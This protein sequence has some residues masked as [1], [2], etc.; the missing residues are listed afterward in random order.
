MLTE[1]AQGLKL[2]ETLYKDNYRKLYLYSRAVLRN[3]ELGEEAVQDTFCIACDKIDQVINSG[4]P[5]GWLMNTLKN[6]IRNMEH[7]RSSIYSYLRQTL[8]YKDE[9]LGAASDEINVDLQYEGLISDA[10]FE[11]LKM[12][13]LDKLT[14]LEASNHYG[15]TLEA[16]KKR[17][18]RARE[19]LRNNLSSEI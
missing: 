5:P 6:V 2:L 14:F 17:V 11:L 1:D 12:I 8:E 19:T 15:I 13:Y 7:S 3:P 16:C 10:D 18:Q 4:N 9:V